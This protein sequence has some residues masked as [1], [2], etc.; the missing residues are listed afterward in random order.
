MIQN[1]SNRILIPGLVI[2][3]YLIRYKSIRNDSEG[4]QVIQAF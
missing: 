1:D 3:T 2:R 4:F